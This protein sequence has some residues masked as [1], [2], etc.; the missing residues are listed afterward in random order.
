MLLFIYIHV[1][2]LPSL[3]SYSYLPL[4]SF[5]YTL[6]HYRSLG[7]TALELAKGYAP[8]AHHSPMRVLVLTIEEDPPSLYTYPT[9][10]SRNNTPFTSNFEDF[11]KKCLTKNPKNRLNTD[12]L[13]KHKFI[14][15]NKL[16]KNKEDLIEKLLKYIHPVG[17]SSNSA[18]N[19]SSSSIG[20]GEGDGSRQRL[21]GENMFVSI[22]YV[23]ND[24]LYTCILTVL[25]NNCINCTI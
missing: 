19:N 18:N 2:I 25:Y 4:I 8:Y 21:P 7:I 17:S 13:L 3:I 10:L 1:Y 20:I 5:V 23:I 14:I 22:L 11:Y 6:P 16:L 24:K 9:P 12:E 15:K